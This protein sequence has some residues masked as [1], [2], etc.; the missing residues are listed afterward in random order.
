MDSSRSIL[1]VDDNRDLLEL[2]RRQLNAI[3]V[4]PFIS[5]NVIDAIEI[6][7]NTKIDLLITD[8]NMPN[9]SGDQLVRYASE[10]HP[11]L[12]TLVITGYPNVD[13]A[14]HVMKLG[15]IEYLIKPFTEEELYKVIAKI[16]PKKETEVAT[17]VVEKKRDSFMGIIGASESMQQ[18]YDTIERTKSNK[19]TV[20][21]SG[22]SGTGK[23]LVARAI[24]Y[25]SDYSSAPFVPVNCGAIPEQLIES[26]L[27]GHIKEVLPVPF[28][29]GLAF[30]KLQMEEPFS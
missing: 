4:N 15:A 27:F 12:P 28:L 7:D 22:E 8:M 29:I 6:L 2:I 17:K 19:A 13:S 30:F 21:I 10:H 9:I 18:L 23:E 5:D 3:G 11:G 24:H 14:V 1:V 20:L 25:N 26:E 16:L